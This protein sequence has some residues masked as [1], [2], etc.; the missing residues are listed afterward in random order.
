MAN[1]GDRSTLAARF[2]LTSFREKLHLSLF[3]IFVPNSL[4]FFINIISP[5]RLRAICGL[6]R[7]VL[8]NAGGQFAGQFVYQGL[9]LT[10]NHNP[11]KRFGA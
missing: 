5:Y 7:S 4:K 6:A 2:F 9:V 10:F 1:K 3:I 8:R 11:D